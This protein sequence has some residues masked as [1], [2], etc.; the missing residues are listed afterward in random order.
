LAGLVLLIYGEKMKKFDPKIFVTKR[1]TE[2]VGGCTQIVRAWVW[3]D[4]KQRYEAP[5]RGGRYVATRWATTPSGGRDRERK[6]FDDLSEARRWQSGLQ[7]LDPLA[8][9][10]EMQLEPLQDF[11]S[12]RSPT[13]VEVFEQYKGRKFGARRIGTQEQ[14]SQLYRLHISSLSTVRMHE[15]TPKLIDEWIVRLK[16]TYRQ[17]GSCTGRKSFQKELTVL[18]ILMRY[19]DEY[20]DDPTF[21]IPIKKRHR[22]DCMLPESEGEV[23]DR[24]INLEQMLR[25]AAKALEL[26]DGKLWNAMLRLQ[27]FTATR[28]CELAALRWENV[29]LVRTNPSESYLRIVEH[30]EWSRTKEREHRIGVGFKNSKTMGGIKEIPLLKGAYEALKDLFWVG[31]RGLVFSADNGKLLTY[32]M[33]QNRYSQAFRMAGVEFKGRGTHSLRHGGCR[34]VY[35]S[36]KDLALAGMLLGNEDHQTIKTYAKKD[37]DALRKFTALSYQES[38]NDPA[39][40]NALHKLA[41]TLG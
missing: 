41:H 6:T 21:R 13:L 27:F 11:A 24:A 18:G 29:N 23:V 31:A 1:V 8:A 20:G 36:S 10:K 33:I 5:P 26:P 38:E 28:I 19:Y 16:K 4:A 34:H 32:R 7:N 9:V 17:K 30:A 3:I 12:T 35:N 22:E 40:E 25:I 37:K 39:L 2:A 14:Y 15:F